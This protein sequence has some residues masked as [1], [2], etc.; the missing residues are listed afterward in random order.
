M[1][2]SARSN[3]RS[4]GCLHIVHRGITIEVSIIP[5]IHSSYYTAISSETRTN[6]ALG[7]PCAA[8]APV[9]TKIQVIKLKRRQGE[10]NWT[11]GREA[12]RNAG[13]VGRRTPIARWTEHCRR[14]DLLLKVQF[15]LCD[16]SEI[17]GRFISYEFAIAF[18]RRRKEIRIEEKRPTTDS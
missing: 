9:Y 6:S 8:G 7:E 5:K 11:R 15:L 10:R 17:S 3:Y 4:N 13:C 18:S 14:V 12:S 1:Y 2:T 16:I